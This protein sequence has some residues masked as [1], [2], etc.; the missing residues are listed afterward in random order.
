MQAVGWKGS[1]S[2]IS[3]TK[4]SKNP[5]LFP[6]GGF[7]WAHRSGRGGNQ[8]NNTAMNASEPPIP[9]PPGLGLNPG[10]PQAREFILALGRVYL[11]AGL[12]LACALEAA[13]ADYQSFDALSSAE[14]EVRAA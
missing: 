13:L 4:F 1:E 7:F 6:G 14:A 8:P 5:P 12:P 11:E 10:T 2:T 9:R 3:E